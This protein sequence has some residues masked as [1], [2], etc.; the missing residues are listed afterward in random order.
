MKLIILDNGHGQETKG[1]QSPLWP[2]NTQ[3]LEWEYN[4]KVVDAVYGRLMAG[5]H[6][7]RE[8]RAREDRHAPLREGET[9]QRHRRDELHI[10]GAACLRPCER[11]PDAWF[12]LRMG[13]THIPRTDEVR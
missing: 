10:P 13:D 5:G 4:R 8:T 2:D 12:R 9:G 7:L 3:F 1:K 6:Q 11:R